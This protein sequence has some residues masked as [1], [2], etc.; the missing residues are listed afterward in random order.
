MKNGLLVYERNKNSIFNIGDYI[1]SLAASQFFENKDFVHVNR[2]HLNE[3]DGDDIKLIMNGWFMQEPQNWPPSSKIHP[4]FVSFHMNS[5][6]KEKMMVEK[7]INYFKQHEPIGCR[8]FDTVSLLKS[9]GVEAYFSGCLTLTLGKSYKS[10][11]TE[12]KGVYFVD[13]H[14][15][16]SRKLLSI[17][18]IIVLLFKKYNLISKLAKKNRGSTSIRN[19]LSFSF[20]YASYSKIFTDDVLKNAEYVQHEIPDSFDSDEKKF[21]YAESLLRKYSEAKYI[22][23]SRIHCALPCLSMETPVLYVE[24]I[25]QSEASYCRLNGLREL[26]N[27]IKYNKGN[28]TSEFIKKKITREFTFKNKEDYK[29]FYKKLRATVEEFT[30]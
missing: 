26:L 7:S 17:L 28:L 5:L 1:Q 27:V 29:E 30:R 19:L 10:K 4:F 20:F 9:K 14:H 6:A 24:N 11:L 2:E 16:P 3:Y 23:T 15:V 13:A 25:N 18:S 22:V 21:E 12:K 8:D